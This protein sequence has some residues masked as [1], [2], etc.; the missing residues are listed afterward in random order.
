MSDAMPPNYN[1][2]AFGG[3]AGQ[4][5][6]SAPQRPAAVD[7]GFWLLIASAVLSVIGLIFTIMEMNSDDFR[8]DLQ[9]QSPELSSGDLDMA[10]SIGVTVAVVI[11]VI[12]VAVSILFAV[13]ARKGYN[14]ARI[15][16]T[17]FAVLSLIGLVGVDGSMGGILGV[18]SILLNIAAV[19]MFFTAPASAY[20][21]EMKQYRQAKKL[22]Y[23]G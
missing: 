14:W 23:A 18:L 21:N 16:V 12:S 6:P 2:G 3:Q 5:A 1:Y 11:A 22:G 13:L 8:T 15:V 7:R 9:S 10:I 19:V 17:V 20:F 4:Q